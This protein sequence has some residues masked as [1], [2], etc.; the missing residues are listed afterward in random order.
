MFAGYVVVGS[1]GLIKLEDV[2]KCGAGTGSGR[3]PASRASSSN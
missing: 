3:W 2:E 1:D